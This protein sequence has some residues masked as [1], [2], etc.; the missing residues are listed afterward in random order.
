M[1]TVF[2][3]VAP[4]PN[5]PDIDKIEKFGWNTETGELIGSYGFVH[6]R[7]INVDMTYQRH[8]KIS[9]VR[10]I[11]REWNWESL[12]VLYVGKR[13]DGRFYI[14]DGQHRLAAALNRSDVELLPCIIYQSSGP[15]FEAKMFLEIN[16]KS[17]RVS[18]NETFKT[19][20]V[21][22]D[23]ISTAIKRVADDLGIH[24][25]EKSGGS[26]PRKISC[27]DTIVSAW[28]TNPTAAEKCFRLASAIAIDT[29]IT[30]DLFLGLFTLNK[31]LEAIEDEVFNYSQRLIQA[32]HAEIMLSI[33]KYNTLL[34]KG[35]ENTYASGIL[36][37]IN[38]H[39]RNKIKVEGLVY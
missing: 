9:S 2:K 30:K 16:R 6:K 19:N 29:A 1:N 15:R 28:K 37:V 26:S 12:G 33:R 20:L 3:E 23:P 32:G 22:G 25:K 21:I 8:P 39:R 10:R 38:K 4:T 11:S 36:S 5:G 18:P 27:I 35:G 24:V 13:I 17:R 34:N 7:D 31:K 14:I